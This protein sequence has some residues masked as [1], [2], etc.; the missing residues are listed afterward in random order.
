DFTNLSISGSFKFPRAIQWD[1][2]YLA[3][4]GGR[5]SG[6]HSD[7]LVY[8]VAFSGSTGTIVGKQT[9]FKGLLHLAGGAFWIRGNTVLLRLGL[10]KALGP[11][12]GVYK[13]P[14]GGNPTAT[15]PTGDALNFA[16]T[17]SVQPSR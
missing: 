4:L 14:G 7:P 11:E 3:V 12:V 1:G 2:T 8:R 9:K 15:I 10:T 13:Y 16:F 17:V 5:F 6:K